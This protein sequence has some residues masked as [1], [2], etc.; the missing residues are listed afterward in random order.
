MSETLWSLLLLL[1]EY[2][3]LWQIQKGRRVMLWSG[4]SEEEMKRSGQEQE[5]ELL[6]GRL[7][8]SHAEKQVKTTS[9]HGDNMTEMETEMK[10]D[11]ES[12]SVSV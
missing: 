3:V 10:C 1:A 4:Q 5:V 11:S 7:Q 12:D 9:C 6:Q 2:C 8:D